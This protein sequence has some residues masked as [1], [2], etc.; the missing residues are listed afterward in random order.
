MDAPL[1]APALAEVLPALEKPSPNELCADDEA[2]VGPDDAIV[3]L[4]LAFEELLLETPATALDPD[5]VTVEK[6]PEALVL[7]ENPLQVAL[8]WLDT[9]D[10]LL[11]VLL[12]S[13]LL[14][15]LLTLLVAPLKLEA[16]DVPV[17]VERTPEA[18]VV[19]EAYEP[20]FRTLEPLEPLEPLV[21]VVALAAL[22]A[23]FRAE[24][25]VSWLEIPLEVLERSKD[26]DPAPI[27]EAETLLGRAPELPETPYLDAPLDALDA[28]LAEML[29]SEPVKV[30]AGKPV[31]PVELAWPE[32]TGTEM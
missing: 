9:P 27:D 13:P 20:V 5:A 14:V 23:E 7:P 28:P 24:V 32:V 2:G 1:D 4:E 15:P 19:L 18:L 17:A 11:E 26:E 30:V 10:K 31:K 29:P 3:W 21:A 6:P 12:E 22:E 25:V 16:V 8:N